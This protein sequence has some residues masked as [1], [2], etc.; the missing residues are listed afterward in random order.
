[1]D[2]DG[3]G[4]EVGDF[5]AEGGEEGT[6]FSRAAAWRGL[7]GRTSGMRRPLAFEGAAG[8]AGEEFF[9]EDA[10]VEGVLVDDDEAVGGFGDDVGVVELDEAVG[11]GVVSGQWPVVG[12]GVLCGRCLWVGSG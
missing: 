9:V 8:G 1:M 6:D 5:D 12:G 4:V 11:G 3:L 7:M 10:F 2:G